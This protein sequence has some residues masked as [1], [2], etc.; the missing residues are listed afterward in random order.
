MSNIIGL[1]GRL[2]DCQ[3]R[4]VEH[5]RTRGIKIMVTKSGQS[6]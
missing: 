1:G 5:K 2:G 6:Q 4:A 3:N